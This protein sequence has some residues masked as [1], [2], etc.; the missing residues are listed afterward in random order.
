MKYRNK[1]VL[2]EV[3]AVTFEELVE[4][5]RQSGA[6]T[7]NGM[8]WSFTFSGF[9]I[10]HET[11]DCYL[12]PT[13]DGGTAQFRR[14]EGKVLAI[15]QGT[16][17]AYS[18][19]LFRAAFVPVQD[20]AKRVI[21]ESPL[22]NTLRDNGEWERVKPG[23][24]EYDSNVAFAKACM[25]DSLNRGE[26]PFASHLLYARKGVFDDADETHRE[27][28]MKAGF[29]WNVVAQEAIVYTDLGISPG[30]VHGL[31]AH[32]ARGLPVTFRT[33]H[34]IALPH[35]QEQV[36]RAMEEIATR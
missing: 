11:D 20:T 19:E 34:G 36:R 14:G 32:L 4:H 31:R 6:N 7:V 29:A 10:T 15:E 22:G 33:L 18:E 30:M 23:S 24:R 28:G 27:I 21:L 9:P 2:V 17:R 25:A 13:Q 35:V 3:E 16:L 12:I 26:A 5:G 8:P 1:P